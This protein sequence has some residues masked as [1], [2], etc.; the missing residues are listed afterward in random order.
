[1]L[2]LLIATGNPG[3]I[4]ELQ[5]LLKDLPVK[6][7]TP[8]DVGLKDFDVVEDGRTYAEN[9]EKKALAYCQASGLP[10]LAD[11]SGLEVDALDGAP[12]LHSARYAPQPGATDADRRALMVKNL[13]GLPQPWTAR[14][15]C[16]VAVA[17]PEGAMELTE[18]TC[19]GEIIPEE[20]GS[21][22]FGYDPIF[23]LTDLG[24]TMAELTRQQKNTLSH[25]ARAVNAAIPLLERMIEE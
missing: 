14:F 24:R 17:T 2:T 23:M 7:V 18:G 19:E 5:D 1:M 8:A 22:G 12:G 15:R 13:R 10:V 20:R 6:L 11:D 9:A 16:T 21:N 4:I 25:R 3:K